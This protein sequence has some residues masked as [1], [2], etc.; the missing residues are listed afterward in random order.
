MSSRSHLD[1]LT[2]YPRRSNRV[3]SL[4]RQTPVVTLQHTVDSVADVL[5]NDPSLYSIAVLDPNNKPVGI[6]RRHDFMH[7]FLSRYGRELYGRKLIT[8]FM[9]NHPLIIEA[10]LSLEE[11]S[12]YLTSGSRLSPEHDFIIAEKGIYR[13]LGH[14]M[15]LLQAMTELQIRNARY[16]NPLTQLPGNVPIYEYIENLLAQKVNFAVAYC[17]LDNFKPFNDNYGYEQGDK[18]IKTVAE[19]LTANMD[20]EC[21]FVGHV[22]GDDFIVVMQSTDWI[23]RCESVLSLFATQALT[24]YNESDRANGGIHAL[25]RKGNPTF[26]SFLSLSIGAVMPDPEACHSH[27]DVAALASEAKHQAKKLN[28]NQLFID[29]RRKPLR[30]AAFSPQAWDDEGR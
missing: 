10:H 17:D 30:P 26:Y 7:L 8:H 5:Y 3:D 4:I 9:D 13:G 20:E 24:F 2:S 6:V 14:I 28:G 1:Y 18:V 22:G 19:L 12:C 16:A 25:D 11:A 27:H 15:D 21:D 23:V 29:R